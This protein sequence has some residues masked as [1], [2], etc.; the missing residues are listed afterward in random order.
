MRCTMSVDKG[1]CHLYGELSPKEAGIWQEHLKRCEACR[2]DDRV[3]RGVRTA[4]SVVE[5]P[6]PDA[7][8][9]AELLERRRRKAVDGRQILPWISI[10]GF[11]R[12]GFLRPALALT[13]L[14]VVFA[15]FLGIV[16][17]TLR[18]RDKNG[19][20]GMGLQWND[21]SQ[22]RL[23]TLEEDIT[24]LRAASTQGRYFSYMGI[25][26]GMD[27]EDALKSKLVELSREMD[28]F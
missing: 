17:P 4:L 28:S 9:L 21:G 3:L 5:M 11:L 16:T 12:G 1:V 7:A 25:D 26:S 13:A 27:A 20:A 6:E 22:T 15:V 2:E 10:F 18:H 14:F 8:T 23:D 24:E 19:S